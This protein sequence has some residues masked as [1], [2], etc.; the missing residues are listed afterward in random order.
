MTENVVASAGVIVGVCVCV[1][2]YIAW[3]KNDIFG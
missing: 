2:V 1:I 3:C